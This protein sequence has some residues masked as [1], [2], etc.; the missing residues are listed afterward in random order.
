MTDVRVQV[1]SE[2]IAEQSKPESDQYVYTY[3]ITITNHSGHPAQLI[4]RHWTITD[5]ENKTQEVTGLGVVGEQPVIP[6]GESYTYT[7]GVVMETKNGI[8]KGRYT[9]QGDTGEFEATVPPFA[10]VQPESLH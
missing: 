8:M 7:S 10:L 9:M 2:Y 4:S 6:P 5:A 3:T 1:K